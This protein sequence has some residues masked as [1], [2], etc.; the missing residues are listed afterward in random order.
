LYEWSWPIERKLDTVA[1]RIYGAKSVRYQ[2]EAEQ[3]L[4]L[5]HKN[6]FGALPICVCKT[7]YSLSDDPRQLGRPND[8][9][10]TVREIALA[11]GA[12]FVI[13]ITG[14]IM[15]MPGLP[16]TPAAEQYALDPDGNV[17]NLF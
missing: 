3:D 5:L 13:P 15:R 17:V 16:K 8:F 1:R 10:L 14:P 6:G 4:Q 11:A 9:T 12:G 2:V 7:Q